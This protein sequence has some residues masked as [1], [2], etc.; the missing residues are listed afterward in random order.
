[1]SL[2]LGFLAA[3]AAVFVFFTKSATGLIILVGLGA[4]L[5]AMLAWIRFGRMLR[6]I[7]YGVAVAL[8]V[9]AIWLGVTHTSELLQVVGRSASLTGRVPLWNFVI[10]IAERR[11]VFGYGLWTLWRFGLFRNLAARG[12]V[13]ES[14]RR[15]S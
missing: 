5:G 8:S 11:P 2:A 4:S 15:F 14:D 3:L 1:M 13:G 9:L 6:P 12:S 10:S 7:H